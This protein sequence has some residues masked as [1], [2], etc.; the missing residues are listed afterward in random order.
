MPYFYLP[1][2]WHHNERPFSGQN[3]HEKAK[4]KNNII[5]MCIQIL[6]PTVNLVIRT[7]NKDKW[8]I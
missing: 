3:F 7:N 4:F 5:S 1:A 6:P 2:S 8:I